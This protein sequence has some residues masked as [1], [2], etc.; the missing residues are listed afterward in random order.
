[1]W[2]NAHPNT[3]PNLNASSRVELWTMERMKEHRNKIIREKL[4]DP[5]DICGIVDFPLWDFIEPL[6]YI[7]PQLH[8]EIGLVNYVLENFY[9]FDEDQVEVAPPEEHMACN[10]MILCDVAV[11][12]AKESV[13]DWNDT[14]NADL[15]LQCYSKLQLSKALKAKTLLAMERASLLEQQRELDE[16][17]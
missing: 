7:L 15:A 8:I 5:K 13:D 17:I 4:K 11:I 6:H 3:W 16:S 9:D 2:C 10:S 14:G 1:M 12:K